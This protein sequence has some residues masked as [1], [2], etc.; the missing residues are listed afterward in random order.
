MRKGGQT[1]RVVREIL[2]AHI[3]VLVNA[4]GYV[5]TREI[6]DTLN[7][8]L[9]NNLKG[10][11]LVNGLT[12]RTTGKLLGELKKRGVLLRDPSKLWRVNLPVFGCRSFVGEKRAE[13][14]QQGL[15]DPD[16][17]K[18]EGVTHTSVRMWRAIRG[19]KSNYPQGWRGANIARAGPGGE[20]K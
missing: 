20:P 8:Q 6:E 1:R 3:V 16:I 9:K 7:H 14:Y 17:A 19:L 5:S 4:R 2:R 15:S 11:R 12:S 18:R 10:L 13:L